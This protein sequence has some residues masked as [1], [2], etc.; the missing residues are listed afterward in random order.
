[1]ALPRR[2]RLW[3]RTFAFTT[4]VLAGTTLAFPLRTP[5]GEPEKN[6]ATIVRA[7][8][9]VYA[10]GTVTDIF[11]AA[12]ILADEDSFPAT[13][14]VDTEVDKDYMFRD[15]VKPVVTANFDGRPQ[16]QA[17]IRSSRKMREQDREMYFLLRAPA[18]FV[19]PVVTD[20]IVNSL[21]LIS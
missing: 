19:G 10:L 18:G 8:I 9:K 12:M 15:I 5:M 7:I 4:N 1:M 6:E 14:R 20:T 16:L 21:W 13:L 17:D 3:A 11:W 2:K